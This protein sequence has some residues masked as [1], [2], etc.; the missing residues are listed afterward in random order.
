M[1]AEEKPK[2]LTVPELKDKLQDA[3]QPTDGKKDELVERLEAVEEGSVHV[4]DYFQARFDP[5]D[6]PDDD[7]GPVAGR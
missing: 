1:P 5:T 6:P 3:G 2:D 7:P 4:P